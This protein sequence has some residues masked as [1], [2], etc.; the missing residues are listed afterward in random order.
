MGDLEGAMG[1]YD[2][3]LRHNQWSIPAMTAISSILRI[4]EQFHKAIEYLQSILKIDAQNGDAW[5][6]LGTLSA[7][8]IRAFPPC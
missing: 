7:L 6:N 8:S 2:H 1:A 4:R 3:A 5:G